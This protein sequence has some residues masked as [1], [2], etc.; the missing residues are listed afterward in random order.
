[1]VNEDAAMIFDNLPAFAN[2]TWNPVRSGD[3]AEDCS[4]GRETG[5]QVLLAVRESENPALL[6]TAIR[7]MVEAGKYGGVEAGFC[8]VFGMSLAHS[9]G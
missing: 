9:P 6:G 1:M 4:F 5:E 7:A 2:G 3:Y 8:S